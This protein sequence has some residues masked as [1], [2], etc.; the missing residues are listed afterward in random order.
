MNTL[1]EIYK[2]HEKWLRMAKRFDAEN[3]DDIVQD[4]YIK[5]HCLNPKEVN[6]FFI[7]KTIKSLFIDNYRKRKIL[8][9]PLNGKEA[10][11]VADENDEEDDLQLSEIPLT[12]TELL[13]IQKLYGYTTENA[14]TLQITVHKGKSLLSISKEINKPYMALYVALKKAKKKIYEHRIRRFNQKDNGVL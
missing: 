11:S 2:G 12:G 9:V 7:Y 8:T 3:A 5:V 4:M 6:D 1:L 10:Y 14:D 13:I